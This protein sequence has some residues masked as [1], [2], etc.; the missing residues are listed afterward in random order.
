MS[1]I[2]STN[3]ITSQKII[4]NLEKSIKE[5]IPIPNSEKLI[6][7]TDRGTQFTSKVYKNFIAK[8]NHMVCPSMSRENTP[9]DNS[10][11]ERFMRTFKEDKIYDTTIKEA[12]SNHIGTEPNYKS[13]RAVLNRYVRNLNTKPNKKSRTAPERHDRSVSA[14][15]MLMAPPKYPQAKSKN[16]TNDFRIDEV[17]KFKAE[18]AK[19]IGIL[20]KLA[21]KKAELVDKTPFDN[22]EDNI[23][24][25]VIDIKLTELYSLINNNPQITRQYVEEVIEPVEESL[26]QL[27]NKVDQLLKKEKKH[28]KTLPLRDPLDIN[29]FPIFLT[30]AGNQAKQQKDLRQA[31]LRVA[32]T[33]L[34]FT[35]LRIS[36]IR[37]ITEKQILDA[38]ASSTLNAIH[39]K[40]KE[41]HFH[42]LSKNGVKALKKLGPELLTIFQKY[43][44]KYLFGKCKPIHQKSLT[45]M[46]NDDLKHTCKINN[47]PYNIK[48]HS[49]RINFQSN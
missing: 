48:L 18:N 25:Q 40:T 6:I 12:L 30:N 20:A 10:V 42:V 32:Y 35:G 31:Q 34:Y 8:Y 15:S 28:K 38:K 1:A 22:F 29:L 39:H 49:F 45:R 36:E 3:T 21:A 46:I 23:I 11:A 14:A 9:T 4:R 24:L 26:N 13:F 27:H 43:N 37:E 44:Y 41:A 5:R 17:E 33:L 47:I 16:I 7:H 19:V 2:L